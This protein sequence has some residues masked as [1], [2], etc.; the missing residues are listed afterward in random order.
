MRGVNVCTF[1]GN[2]GADPELKLLPSGKAVAN[3]SM[4]VTEGRGDKEVTEWVSVVAWEKTAEAASNFLHKGS[5]IYVQGRMQTRSWEHEGRK[6]FK[7]EIVARDIVFLDGKDVV[8]VGAPSSGTP[9]PPTAI[10][11]DDIPF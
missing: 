4:A 3:F 11:D 1:I 6:H 10:E 9:P 7:T 5:R 8:F 2:L